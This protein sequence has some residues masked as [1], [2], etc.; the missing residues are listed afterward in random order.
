VS[1]VF[2]QGTIEATRIATNVAIQG[3]GF[4]VLDGPDGQSYSRAGAF[5]FDKNGTL[6]SPD[7]QKVQGYTAIDPVTNQVI[8]TGQTT[9]I[10]VAP[11]VLRAPV[12]TSQFRPLTNLDASAANGDTFTTSI[13]MFD[14][15]GASHV[16][17]MTYTKTGAG[18]WDYELTADGAD[19]QGG[20]TGV[21]SS[22]ATGSLTFDG[23]GTLTGVNGGAPTDV[24]IITPA[25]SNGATAS[26]L[27]WDILDAQRQAAP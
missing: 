18:A 25:W 4:F 21:P 2:S 19:V 3:N 23:T 14:S 11:G 12:A 9:A 22:L 7:G 16:T 10:T 24:S 5:A 20:T 17:T 8:T 26:S 27:Q 15:L 6:V 1:S 13:Q